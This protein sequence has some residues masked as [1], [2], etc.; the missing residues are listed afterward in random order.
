MTEPFIFAFAITGLFIFG[1][2]I[3]LVVVLIRINSLMKSNSESGAQ[4]LIRLQQVH[5][6]SL[7]EGFTESRKEL[8]EVSSENRKEMQV[9]FKD[10]QDTLL[11]RINENSS[12]QHKQ[13][14]AFKSALNALSERLIMNSNEFKQSVTLSF[15]T[16]S[17]ALNRKQDE[18]RENI[19]TKFDAFDVSMKEDA[20]INR[21]DLN[22]GLKA[23]NELFEKIINNTNDFKQSVTLSFQSS[24]DALNRKQDEFR[25]NI[26]T[27]FDTFDVRMK[28]DAKINRQDLNEGLK[29]LN[30][31]FEKI[32]NNTNDF[33]QSVTLSLQT[34]STSLN[35]K[36]DEFREKTIQ[37]LDGFEATIKTDAK[38]NRQELNDGLKSF[39][40]K[41]SESIK[42]FNGQLGLKFSD[43]NKQQVDATTQAKA[44]ITEIREAIEKQLKSIREDNTQQL[45]EM[46][47]TVDEKLQS[48]LEKRLG[49]SF[50]QVSDRLEQV[51]K[52]LGEMQTLAIGVG[53]LKKVLANVKTRG[54]LGEYQLG[55]ILEQILSPD[56]YAMNVATKLGSQANVE[57][58]V[59]LPGKSDE[60]T[61]WLP[62]DS[63]FPLESY[64]V[65]LQA[66]EEADPI[67][68]DQSQKL[69]LKVVENFAKDISAKYIDPPHTTDFA[70]MFLPVES[71]FAEVLRHP[72][73]FELLQ[74]KYRI[75]IT[76][77]TTL[78]ALLNSLHMGFRTLAVQKRSSEVWKVLAEVKTEFASYSEQLALVHKQL[79]TASGSLE[80]LKDTRTKAMERKLRDVA[81]LEITQDKEVV[82]ILEG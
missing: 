68:I 32:I 60:K 81:V 37:K 47:K 6:I 24:S 18:F 21:Q 74:R 41:F 54:I 28:E 31:L 71:L 44:S 10:F 27:K 13:L 17:D 8:R 20:K 36:Q 49:E 75:T 19:I 70:I 50:K 11:N 16:S 30:E 25:E 39:E 1:I 56:Q 57:F 12:E 78:S 42:E 2:L 64:Q 14:D 23:L 59:K 62:M 53:D 58:A 66:Y 5:E 40:T 76:G 52:G 48:T 34:S 33:K 73:M 9:S 26:I 3:L 43:L 35:Q 38:L 55:N 67:K 29:A 69:L 7:K 63:K 77:P 80:K 51:H 79:T 46:R 65:L 22:E 82:V 4:E 15:Q 45:T 72:H 61:V